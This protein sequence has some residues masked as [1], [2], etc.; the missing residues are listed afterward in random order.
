LNQ[1]NSN[2]QRRRFLRR[3]F[4]FYLCR[5]NH[6]IISISSNYQAEKLLIKAIELLHVN[7]PSILFSEKV[8]T[9]PMG[10]GYTSNFFNLA[11]VFE[12]PD[13]FEQLNAQFKKMEMEFGRTAE[14]KLQKIVPLDI[15]I[16][17]WNNEVVREDYYKFPVLREL[18]SQIV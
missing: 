5:M 4:C 18:I 14:L 10:K 9:E 8:E 12:C 15:D 6:C 17:L 7:F 2:I 13:S 11:A 3:F 1:L 16:I